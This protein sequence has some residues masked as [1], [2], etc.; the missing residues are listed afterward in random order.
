MTLWKVLSGLFLGVA[1]VFLL[2]WQIDGC[3]DHKQIA[4]VTLERDACRNAPSKSDTVHD[5]IYIQGGT[6]IKPVPYKVYIHDTVLVAMKESWYD[7]TYKGEGWRFRY[8]LKTI[9]ELDHI[10]FSD[11]VAP[12]EIIT[13]TRKVD[14]CIAKPLPHNPLLRAGPYVGISLN[15][16]KNFPGLEVGGQLTIKDQFTISA[17]YLY[18]DN[19]YLNIRLGWLFR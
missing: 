2:I 11:F 17:G 12:K 4:S 13:I 5:T 9:G 8:R 14:T 1:L 15:N 19:S 3:K 6:M 7:S 18:L 16:F 10:I